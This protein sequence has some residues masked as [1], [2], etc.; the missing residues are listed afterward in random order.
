[1]IKISMDNCNFA[2]QKTSGNY[3][4]LFKIKKL[5]YSGKSRFQK[6][7]IF[8]N[9]QFGRILLLDNFVQIAESDEFFYHEYL[10]HPAMMTHP[11]PKNVL[12]IGGGDGG[13]IEE[14]AKYKGVKKITMVEIDGDVVELS[15]K[16][17]QSVCRSAFQDSRVELIIDDGRKFIE[18]TGEKYDVVILDLTDPSGPSKF[19]FTKEFYSMIRDKFPGAVVSAQCD[20]PSL[21]PITFG[22]IIATQKSVFRNVLPYTMFTQSFGFEESFSVMSQDYDPAKLNLEQ[23]RRRFARERIQDLKLYSPEFHQKMFSLSRYVQDI[24][25]EKREISTDK[26]PYDLKKYY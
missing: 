21:C 18:Q 12:V 8:E 6:V 10:V 4:Q 20:S 7:D 2:V 1:M 3:Y 13:S 15:R 5:I 24:L 19:L 17:L 26:N 9:D 25:A 11:N 14:V 22:T 23:L 16:Y